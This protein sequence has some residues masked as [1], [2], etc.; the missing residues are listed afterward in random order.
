[1]PGEFCPQHEAK[2]EAIGSHS[3]QIEALFGAIEKQRENI[4]ELR[5]LVER[6]IAAEEE[7]R[8][9]QA[10]HETALALRD[11]AMVDAWG[12][13]IG[14]AVGN[15]VGAVLRTMPRPASPAPWYQTI[16]VNVVS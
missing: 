15:S 16:A 8:R 6:H 1:M 7:R 4:G 3:S 11:R 12:R 13:S 5:S 9:A 14:E 10:E 2:S